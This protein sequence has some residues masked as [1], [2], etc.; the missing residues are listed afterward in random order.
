MY[1]RSPD[2]MHS[3]NADITPYSRSADKIHSRSADKIHSWCSDIMH[4]RSADIRRIH[5]RDYASRRRVSDSKN[6]DFLG[7]LF[8]IS[9]RSKK[10][11]ESMR[12]REIGRFIEKSGDLPPKSGG[13]ACLDCINPTFQLYP[14]CLAS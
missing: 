13:L 7:L 9:C 10:A 11:G 12:K 6:N 1:S 8:K 2:I 3:R 5:V 4:S 14:E